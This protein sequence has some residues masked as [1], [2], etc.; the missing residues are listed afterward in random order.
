MDL[1]FNDDRTVSITMNDYIKKSIESYGGKFNGGCTTPTKR[2]L[3][4][5]DESTRKLSEDRSNI[6][7]HIVAKLFFVSKRSR[8]DIDLTISFFCGRV[9]RSTEQD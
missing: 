8:P 5:I 4:D 6:F 9:D 7:H 3:F 2:D 1:T